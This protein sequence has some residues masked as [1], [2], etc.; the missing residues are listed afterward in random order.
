VS[1]EAR[2]A[3]TDRYVTTFRMAMRSDVRRPA[4]FHFLTAVWGRSYVQLY[5]D[6]VIPAQLAAGNLPA[7][8][9]DPAT[10]YIIFTT[11]TD[12][13]RIRAA[14][15]FRALSNTV[16]T[17]IELIDDNLDVPHDAMSN[18]YRRGIACADL[19][20]AAIVFLTP[21]I[22]F[23]DHSFAALK[24]LSQQGYEAVF[25]PAIRALK[26]SVVPALQE[27]Y[28]SDGV[29]Q[30][31]S[32]DLM[33]M[34]FENPHPIALSSYWEEGEGDL[35]APILY[36]RVADEGIVARCFH[37]HPLLVYPQR[38]NAPFLGTID[39]DF[40]SAACPDDSR[41]YVVV[42][43]D[44]IAAVELSGLER[45][46]RTGIPKQSVDGVA[47]WAELSANARHRKLFQRTIRMHARVSDQAAWAE[48]EARAARAAAAIERKLARPWWKLLLSG[49]GAFA[50][51][52]MRYAVDDEAAGANGAA[53]PFE[54]SAT[55]S[56]GASKAGDATGG[57]APNL[58]RSNGRRSLVGIGLRGLARAVTY[59]YWKVW[60]R[61][62][63]GYRRAMASIC[64]S[65]LHPRIW[66]L[67]WNFLRRFNRM[68]SGMLAEGREA[69]VICADPVR[70]LP[71]EILREM[72]RPTMVAAFIAGGRSTGLVDI[73]TR[74]PVKTESQDLVV[75]DQSGCGASGLRWAPAEIVRVLRP[76]G[77]LL[78]LA[79]TGRAADHGA[80]EAESILAL[81][82]PGFVVKEQ[83]RLG[84][85]GSAAC[86]RFLPRARSLLA[87]EGIPFVARLLVVMLA[88]PLR[89][90]LVPLIQIG[91][92]ALDF[93]GTNPRNTIL[94]A[95]L[96][97][98][99][100][101]EAR[102][103]HAAGELGKA[104][105]TVSVAPPP[106]RSAVRPRLD[107]V[108]GLK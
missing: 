24:R 71:L 61:V 13:E 27:K 100:S 64:G 69:L 62:R 52:F 17:V 20:G 12:A 31:R 26:S 35:I 68:A 84:G 105:S 70:S 2:D 107:E 11:I 95:A 92:V 32:A 74:E 50:F 7:F 85:P 87:G 10:R 97:V 42:D 106:L 21:D 102:E 46:L 54:M 103:A 88:A 57:P 76:G 1:S 56:G 18:C 94:I 51:R 15:S 44:E 34:A 60:P 30:I 101:L 48:A 75:L 98:K 91:V 79:N 47:E 40:V 6:T 66:S 58:G 37:L 82:N 8:A 59:W 16:A 89:L 83:C 78:I 19:A 86:Q 93:L 39:D 77:Q 9:D 99:R 38:K 4:G 65:A 22:V 43:S 3:P 36:W 53:A 45:V 41:D 63:L 28:R 29:I 25:I 81:L 55:P 80:A 72:K 5:L 104:L 108:D 33:R 23:A 49:D 14:P 73:V 90:F 96:T 67:Q